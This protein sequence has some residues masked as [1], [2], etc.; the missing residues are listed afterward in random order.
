M[1]NLK[2]VR[3]ANREFREFC[4]QFNKVYAEYE[5]LVLIPKKNPFVTFQEFVE[6]LFILG[7]DQLK[8][9]SVEEVLKLER[10]NKC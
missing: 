2:E 5:R 7:I 6:V 3:K 8:K 9:M 10:D 4:S 1:Y